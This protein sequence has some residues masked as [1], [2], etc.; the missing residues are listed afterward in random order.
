MVFR[1]L[2]GGLLFKLIIMFGLEMVSFARNLFSK[3]F[4]LTNKFNFYFFIILKKVLGKL[5]ANWQI[6]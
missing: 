2:V 1:L 3:V 6:H 5:L 4:L